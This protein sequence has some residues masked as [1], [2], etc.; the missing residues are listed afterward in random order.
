MDFKTFLKNASEVVPSERQLQWF[1]TE[2]YGFIHFGVNTFTDKEWGDGTEDPSIFNP[3]KFD[4]EEIVRIFK[5]AGMKGLVITAKHLIF[6]Y[7][8]KIS[9]HCV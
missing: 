8:E 3:Y 5:D 1:S 9:L 6:L 7:Y 2:F 4:A